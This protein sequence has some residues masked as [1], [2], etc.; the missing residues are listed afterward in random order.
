MEEPV[1]REDVAARVLSERADHL[2]RRL[3]A[4]GR[5][6]VMVAAQLVK[7]VLLAASRAAKSAE[8]R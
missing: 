1:R 5:A 6:E 4:V 3:A 2:E 7:R 8:P